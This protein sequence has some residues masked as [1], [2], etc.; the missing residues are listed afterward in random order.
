MKCII[1][2]SLP[3]QLNAPCPLPFGTTLFTNSLRCALCANDIFHSQSPTAAAN[4]NRHYS[5]SPYTWN[6]TITWDFVVAS[7]TNQP[8]VCPAMPDLTCRGI[9]TEGFLLPFCYNYAESAPTSRIIAQSK[10]FNCHPLMEISLAQWSLGSVND[11]CWDTFWWLFH[12]PNF[13]LIL[14]L[15]F[16]NWSLVNKF[17]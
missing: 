6:Q 14:L 12:L 17:C 3:V 2:I 13:V 8:R 15:P 7:T 9:L 4:A 1:N 11:P 16:C 10:D 5:R